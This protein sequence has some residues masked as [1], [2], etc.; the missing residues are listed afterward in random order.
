MEETIEQRLHSVEKTLAT[1]ATTVSQLTPVKKT[2]AMPLANFV[3]HRSIARL[4]ALERR[5]DTKRTPSHKRDFAEPPLK[6]A[7]GA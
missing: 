6:S 7:K 2:G 4:T 3:T 5:T 1:L